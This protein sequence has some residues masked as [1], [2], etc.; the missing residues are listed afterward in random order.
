M[1]TPPFALVGGGDVRV[2]LGVVEL[3][4]RGLHHDVVVAQ[5][6]V[7]DLRPGDLEVGVGARAGC[8]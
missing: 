4:A 1:E 5:L 6:A 7:V 8:P 2:A 3:G